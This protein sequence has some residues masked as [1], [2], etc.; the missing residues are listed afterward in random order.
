MTFLIGLVAAFF[1]FLW[2]I[3][4]AFLPGAFVAFCCGIFLL[5][6][7]VI[8]DGEGTNAFDAV[9]SDSA[10]NLWYI[11]VGAMA[12]WLIKTKIR[13]HREAQSRNALR[14]VRFNDQ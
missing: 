12:P 2:W 5:Y 1:F 10:K 4:G 8:P 13:Q 11:A 9:T 6:I 7:A 14:D 3:R